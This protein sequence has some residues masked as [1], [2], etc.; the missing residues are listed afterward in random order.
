MR[1]AR[2]ILASCRGL[3]FAVERLVHN[4][5]TA[6]FTSALWLLAVAVALMQFFSQKLEELVS[7]LLFGRH[8][9]LK[10]LLL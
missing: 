7:V 1:G 5:I 3:H 10:G 2:A 4:A 9:I 8:Q 6:V